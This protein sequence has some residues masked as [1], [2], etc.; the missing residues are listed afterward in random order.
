MTITIKDLE[1]I[2]H[3]VL[4]PL[5]IINGTAELRMDKC[6][7]ERAT[8][9]KQSKRISDFLVNETKRLE[10]IKL[11]EEGDCQRSHDLIDFLSATAEIEEVG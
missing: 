3:H 8:I 10:E 4:N 1:N 9:M 7:K 6:S 11:R 5:M 2:R